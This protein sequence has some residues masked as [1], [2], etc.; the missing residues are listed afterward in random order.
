MAIQDTVP[1]IRPRAGHDLLVGVE[2]VLPRLGAVTDTTEL[3]ESLM[4]ALVRCAA[5]GDTPRVR[6]QADAVR[7]AATLLRAAEPERA[8]PILKQARAALL[9]TAPLA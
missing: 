8:T 7:L 6:E 4:T 3:A 9:T 2:S 5:R 1:D